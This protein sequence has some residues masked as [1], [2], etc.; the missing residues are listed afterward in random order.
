MPIIPS[1]PVN[2]DDFPNVDHWA[3]AW[4]SPSEE[5]SLTMSIPAEVGWC[6][7]GLVRA[8][9]PVFC[10]ETGTHKGL[11]ALFIGAALRDNGYGRLVT[12]D[13]NDYEQSQRIKS[14]GLDEKWVKCVITRSVDYNPPESI[15]FLFLDAEHGYKAVME[16]LLHFRP[17][18]SGG[19]VIAIDDTR[20]LP[21]ERQAAIDF[22]SSSSNST[23]GF[24]LLTSRGLYLMK[25][26][27]GHEDH[28]EE[29]LIF[30]RSLKTLMKGM[31]L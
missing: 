8:I 27:H 31:V 20:L 15:D 16:E 13:I 18:L 28:N 23:N 3:H 22:I 25:Y 24:Q 26:K 9:K 19:S 4:T 11:S 17:Y 1:V 7:Y 5:W 6:L 29:D 14:R 30:F 10:I 2:D 21:D 12:I